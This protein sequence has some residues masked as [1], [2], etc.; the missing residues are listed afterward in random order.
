MKPSKSIGMTEVMTAEF[1]VAGVV[2]GLYIEK[3][4]RFTDEEWNDY[5]AWMQSVI[6]EKI[7]E[8]E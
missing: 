7:S 6:D 4:W 2:S 3:V 5:I 8:N 1:G